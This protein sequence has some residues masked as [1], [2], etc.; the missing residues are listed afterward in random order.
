MEYKV[1]LSLDWNLNITTPGEYAREFSKE[2][3]NED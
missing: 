3:L 1:L 2:M